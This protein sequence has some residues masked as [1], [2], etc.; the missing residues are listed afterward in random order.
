MTLTRI[1]EAIFAILG[2]LWVAVF[3]AGFIQG[4]GL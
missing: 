1:I 2:A 3:L 4:L